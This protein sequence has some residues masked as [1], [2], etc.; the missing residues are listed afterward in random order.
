MQ[1]EN[2]PLPVPCGGGNQRAGGGQGRADADAADQIAIILDILLGENDL[3]VFEERAVIQLDES[4]G[5]G[6]AHG[7]HP[8]ADRNL[9]NRLGGNGGI[10][11]F[12]GI[13]AHKERTSRKIVIHLLYDMKGLIVKG[14]L[15]S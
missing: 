12:Y 4:K 5:F 13:F 9:L 8:A 10:Q 15:C 2:L 6:I 11:L 3:Q 7:A 1:P 14:N